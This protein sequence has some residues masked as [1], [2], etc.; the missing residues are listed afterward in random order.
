M[1]FYRK[2]VNLLDKRGQGKENYLIILQI[3]KKLIKFEAASFLKNLL[4]KYIMKNMNEVYSV[5]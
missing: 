4:L 5:T 1:I 2:F 3:Y